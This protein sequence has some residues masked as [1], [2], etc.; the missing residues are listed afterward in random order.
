M[1]FSNLVEIPRQELHNV[2]L[3]IYRDYRTNLKITY[4]QFIAFLDRALFTPELSIGAFIESRLVGFQLIGAKQT[5]NGLACYNASAGI[6]PEYRTTFKLAYSGL[7][8]LFEWLKAYQVRHYSCEILEDN[9]PA[10]KLMLKYGASVNRKIITYRTTKMNVAR[11]VGENKRF[12]FIARPD[13]SFLSGLRYSDDAS[14]WQNSLYVI[15]RLVNHFFIVSINKD[16]TIAGF[17]IIHK[18]GG[19]VPKFFIHEEYRRQG[20]GS[21]L[22]SELARQ[23]SSEYISFLNVDRDNLALNEFLKKMTFTEYTTSLE[24]IREWSYEKM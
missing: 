11:N 22:L 20:L 7:D 14:S 10:I 12:S 15:E 4:E 3:K 2:F 1:H 5:P 17:G 6:I 24:L 18:T 23:T 16:R 21:L 8:N 9:R 19:D 13:L